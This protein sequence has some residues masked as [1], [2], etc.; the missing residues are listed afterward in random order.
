ML[1]LQYSKVEFCGVKALF[2]RFDDSI[3]YEDLA[4]QAENLALSRFDR[5]VASHLAADL[6]P[7]VATR[8]RLDFRCCTLLLEIVSDQADQDVSIAKESLPSAFLSL[9]QVLMQLGQDESAL[10]MLG[11][12][13]SFT[14]EISDDSYSKRVKDGISKLYELLRK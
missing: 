4:V 3:G 6:A 14:D 13:E 5:A 12:S 10:K 9:A 7:D 11:I 1:R 8:L 2:N